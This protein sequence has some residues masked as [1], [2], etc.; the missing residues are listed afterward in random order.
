MVTSIAPPASSAEIRYAQCWE[1]A[2]VLLEALRVPRDGTCLSIASG[3]DNSFS[4]LTTGARRVVAID[5][6]PAQLACV[7]LRRAAYRELEHPEFIEFMGSESSCR[8]EGYYR[9]CRPLL[10]RDAREFWDRKPQLIRAG[11]GSSGKFEKLFT[12]FRKQLL[13][14]VH[15]R[16]RVDQL[17]EPRDRDARERFFDKQWNTKLWKLLFRAYC[18]RRILGRGRYPGAFRYVDGAVSER[19]LKRVRHAV[20][21][22]EPWKNPYLRWILTGRHDGALPHALRKENFDRIR[23]NLDALEVVP[24]ALEQYLSNGTPGEINA[25]NL[26]DIFEYVSSGDHERILEMCLEKAAPGA[27]LA[28]WNMLVPR[29]RPESLGDALHSREAEARRLFAQDKAFFYS[30]FVVEEVTGS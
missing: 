15:P 30:A 8:A 10:P 25:F 5:L 27:R 6:N 17:L 28:Y 14:F 9:R 26:S 21:E 18:S 12:L 11:V 19:I 29:S 1:D 4:L 23:E 2:D 3:G 13:P 24:G 22:L 20:V 16:K 7:E